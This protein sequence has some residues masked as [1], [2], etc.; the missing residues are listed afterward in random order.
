MYPA[1]KKIRCANAYFKKLESSLKV[2]KILKGS[3][4]PIP[5]PSHLV[6]IQIMGRKSQFY[7][8]CKGKTLLVIANK[9]LKKKQCFAF[10]SEAN[11]PY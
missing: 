2:E 8:R 10:T 4:D 9:F 3:L 1:R 6:I 7:L 5:S 11:F